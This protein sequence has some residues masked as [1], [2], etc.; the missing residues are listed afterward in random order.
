MLALK[1]SDRRTLGSLDSQILLRELY[2]RSFSI[3]DHGHPNR[4]LSLVG[5]QA[6]EM[7]GQYSREFRTL[8]RFASLRIGELFNISYP[9]FLQQSRERV[10][11]MFQIAEDKT[12]IEDRQNSRIEKQMQDVMNNNQ[13]KP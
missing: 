3:A 13:V 8:R 2:D 1:G 11:W 4:P 9:D 6:K 12:V 5:L 7:Y 10:E